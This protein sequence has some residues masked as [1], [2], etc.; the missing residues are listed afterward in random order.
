MKETSRSV[1]ESIKEINNTDNI[2]KA[3]VNPTLPTHCSTINI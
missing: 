2:F 3:I 1:D